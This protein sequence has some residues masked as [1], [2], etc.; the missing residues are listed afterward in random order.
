MVDSGAWG[1]LIREKNLKSKISWHRPFKHATNTNGIQGLSPAELVKSFLA[2]PKRKI[3]ISGT[4]CL[5]G[6]ALL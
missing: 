4:M 5:C 1:K 3:I 2:L 6:E